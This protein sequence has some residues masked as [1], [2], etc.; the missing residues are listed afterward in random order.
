MIIFVLQREATNALRFE[1]SISP[2]TMPPPNLPDG[3][4]HKFS[5]NYYNTRDPRREVAPPLNL[6]QALIGEGTGEKR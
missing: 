2:R 1:D 4:S 3:P 5:A 6:T